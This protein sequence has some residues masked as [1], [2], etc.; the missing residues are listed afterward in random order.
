MFPISTFPSLVTVMD[1]KAYAAL[2][3]ASSKSTQVKSVYLQLK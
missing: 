3:I 1:A 2:K